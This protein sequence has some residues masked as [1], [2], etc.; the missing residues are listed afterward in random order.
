MGEA[1]T[2]SVSATLPRMTSLRRLRPR[3]TLRALLAA[4]TLVA[5]FLA[6]H[7]NWI[8]ER[9]REREGFARYDARQGRISDVAWLD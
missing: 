2:K 4:M 3:F 8:R 9:Q 5:V 7:F 6:Y 1:L